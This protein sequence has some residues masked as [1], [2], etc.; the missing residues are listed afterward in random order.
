[1]KTVVL[2]SGGI[3]SA[4]AL[5]MQDDETYTLTVD[6]GQRHRKEIESA[7]AIAKHYGANHRVMKLD[8]ALFQ[9][10]ALTGASE[11]P[12]GHAEE[13]DSTY[14]P[15]R[16]TVLLALATA[17]AESVGATK[18]VIGANADDAAG[19]PDCRRTYI[20][21]FRDVILRGTVG[22]VWIHGPL[23]SLTKAQI[24]GLARNMDVPLHLT[25]SCYRGGDQ[26]CG[27]CGACESL[28]GV[29]V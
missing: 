14:V 26:P 5:A 8:P 27:T 17:L 20:E 1:M 16:N 18:V 13:P 7:A 12:D 19:Y 2:L 29:I 11:V 25:W 15:A 28:S 4:L 9:G 21:A 6:Y 24:I 3:D 10:S 23:L 22:H